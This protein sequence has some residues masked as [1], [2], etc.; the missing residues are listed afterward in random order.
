MEHFFSV[1]GLGGYLGQSLIHQ[2]I[3][4]HLTENIP[5]TQGHSD[6]KRGAISAQTKSKKKTPPAVALEKTSWV[7]REMSFYTLQ[8]ARTLG[9]ERRRCWGRSYEH[10]LGLVHG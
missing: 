5:D 3:I 1:A 6:A 2:T 4:D 8:G 10:S 7:G 9:I